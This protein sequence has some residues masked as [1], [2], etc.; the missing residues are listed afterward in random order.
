MTADWELPWELPSWE[1]PGTSLSG[2][3]QQYLPLMI[4]K[5]ISKRCIYI[6][7][8]WPKRKQSELYCTVLYYMKRTFDIYMKRTNH[9]PFPPPSSP[10]PPSLFFSSTPSPAPAPLPPSFS[11]SFSVSFS[12]SFSAWVAS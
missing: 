4:L 11:F 9:S 6:Y 2:T 7:V 5:V 3:Y 8:L 10:S 12:S 1:L